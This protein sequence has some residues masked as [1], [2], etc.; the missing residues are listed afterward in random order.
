MD[1]SKLPRIVMRARPQG[2]KFRA[3][4]SAIARWDQSIAMAAKPVSPNE[5]AITGYIGEGENTLAGV[6]RQLK[7]AGRGNMRVILS[8]PGGDPFEGA[9]IYDELREHPGKVSISVRGIA[10]SAATII[11]MAGDHVEM[12]E[13]ASMMIHGASGMV[14]GTAEDM[15]QFADMLKFI[16][17]SV[18]D[19]YARRSGLALPKV[20]EMMRAETYMTAQESVRLGFADAVSGD[21]EQ[22]KLKKS[23]SAAMRSSLPALTNP[24]LLAASGNAQLGSVLMSA[25]LPGVSG[26]SKGSTAM[27][28]L[29]EQVAELRET[30]QAKFVR[31]GEIH[32]MFQ[33]APESVTAD[34]RAEFDA[35]DSELVT[36]E[37]QIRMKSFDLR[38]E[39]AARP[40]P[41]DSRGI[42]RDVSR[43][44]PYLNLKNKDIDE[45]FKGQN[46]TRK[47]IAMALAHNHHVNPAEIAQ[48]RW[49]KTNPTLVQC[50]R[51]AAV[52]GGGSD[53]GE[54]GS[55]L[56]TADNRFT[57]DFIEYL[58][59][60]T[61]FDQLP[62]REIPANVAVK[63][64]DGAASAAWVGQ[65]KGIPA[66]VGSA[67]SV[68]LSPLKVAALAVVSNELLADS[69]PSAE[70]W[71]RDLL[72]EA[73]SQRV[74]QTFLSATAA[75]AGVSPAGILNGVS[76][77]TSAG[78]SADNIRTDIE[79]L[80]GDF[81]AARHVRN[82]VFVTS[83]GLALAI[84]LMRNALGQREFD[85]VSLTGGTLEGLRLVSGDNVG[86][87]DFILLDPREIWKIGDTGVQVAISR[88]ATIEQDTAPQGATDTPV[89]ASANMTNMFQEDST[90]I[91]LIRRINFQKRRTSAVAFVGDAGYGGVAS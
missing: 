25:H 24:A 68:N 17:E 86:S 7:A 5:M 14:M 84:Q 79:V 66:S 76:A 81:I 39:G 29:A 20:L 30:R 71:V 90:A 28:T 62:L 54:W 61:V 15:L 40:L 11:M 50:I 77:K 56:V 33:T 37:D 91:R 58:Y 67:S 87:G 23:P 63:G 44:A 31:Q 42:H 2:L 85:G 53:S 35:I 64:T 3:P 8:S 38:M 73:M 36:L 47:V 10:A 55:E 82:L 70:M 75:S 26:N 46:W 12:G 9:A 19:L 89:A 69:T 21:D 34:V 65:S 32:Q 52:P 48:Q 80:M 49:G 60:M 27:K 74:D 22:S 6:R 88:E 45:K 59:A 4:A 43:G 1:R 78:T 16:N 57:G 83:T 41:N 72:A 18:A 51:M 13:A